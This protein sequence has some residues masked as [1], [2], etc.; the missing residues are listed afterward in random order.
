MVGRGRKFLKAGLGGEGYASHV[1]AMKEEARR[2]HAMSDAERE[3]EDLA[4][5][6]GISYEEALSRV[7][8]ERD[9]P[10]EKG[11]ELGPA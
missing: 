1:Q 9:R 5:D 10:W 2:R 6:F 4:E 7:E 11:K 8:E 3:A